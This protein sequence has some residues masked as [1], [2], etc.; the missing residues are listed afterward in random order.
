MLIHIKSAHSE[1]NNL[2]KSKNER[3]IDILDIVESKQ[4][5]KKIEKDHKK[6]EE[7]KKEEENNKEDEL[8]KDVDRQKEETENR[9]VQRILKQKEINRN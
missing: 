9:G 1:G 6:D 3:A 5:N 7:V 2:E 8:K 4:E